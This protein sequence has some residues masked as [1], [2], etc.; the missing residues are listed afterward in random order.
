MKAHVSS[1]LVEAASWRNE[2]EGEGC[3]LWLAKVAWEGA[4]RAVEDQ[5]Y[6]VDLRFGRLDELVQLIIRLCTSPVSPDVLHKDG[7]RADQAGLL[8][9]RQLDNQVRTLRTNVAV[10]IN[11][12]AEYCS[13]LAY[14][15]VGPL[16]VADLEAE[17]VGDGVELGDPK[18]I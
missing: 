18:L 15:D 7:A 11:A 14:S 12:P 17:E 10:S 2:K 16:R 8:L 9:G 5:S 4:Q 1:L 3:Q 13:I 6:P